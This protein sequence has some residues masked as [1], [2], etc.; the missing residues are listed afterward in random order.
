MKL[1]FPLLLLHAILLLQSSFA[2]VE[3]ELDSNAP[4]QVYTEDTIVRAKGDSLSYTNMELNGSS[5][6]PYGIMFSAQENLSFQGEYSLEIKN[7]TSNNKGY[8]IYSGRGLNFC[9]MK[10]LIFTNNVLSSSVG[11]IYVVGDMQFNQTGNI[12]LSHNKTSTAP[13]LSA[14][15]NSL[16][17]FNSTG[18]ISMSFNTGYS[19]LVSKQG[20]ISFTHIK[21]L[22]FE[23]NVCTQGDS[24]IHIR[25]LS[26]A[27]ATTLRIEYAGEVKFLNNNNTSSNKG[28]AG[29]ICASNQSAEPFIST[30]PIIFLSADNGNIL[31]QGNTHGI[32][33]WTVANAIV[34]RNYYPFNKEESLGTLSL[35]ARAQREIT[36]YDPII[37]YMKY[38][39]N[40]NNLATV[41]FN[42]SE[43]GIS[44]D[45]TIRFDGS[46]VP[47][48]IV[49]YA[50]E[51]DDTYKQRLADSRHSDIQGNSTLW[52]GFLILTNDVVYGSKLDETQP[53]TSFYCQKGILEISNRSQL[54]ATNF[55]VSGLSAVF[56]MDDS[57]LIV[58]KTFTA[59]AG[60]SFD[61]GYW[62]ENPN[63]NVM[64]KADNASF[65]G[66]IGLHDDTDTYSNNQW[67]NTLSFNLL[68][69][70][71]IVDLNNQLSGIQSQTSG[72]ALVSGPYQYSGTWS[73]EWVG[74]QLVATWTPLAG[75]TDVDP[76][77]EGNIV[78]N[79][80]WSSASNVKSLSHAALANTN[81]LRIQSNLQNNFWM[82]GIGDFAYDDSSADLDG[83][84]YDG[85]GYAAGADVK[86]APKSLIGVAFGQ[87]IGNNKSELYNAK[88]KQESMMGSIYAAHLKTLNKNNSL[89]WT[90]AGSYGDTEN[91]MS[92]H[93]S[94]GKNSTGSWNNN[95][96]FVETQLE[97]RIAP[98]GKNWT[99]KPFIGL[100]YTDVNLE[101]F[102]EKGDKVRFFDEG[103]Y[104]SLALPIGFGVEHQSRFGTKTWL[105]SL[106]LAYVPDVYREAPHTQA[107]RVSNGFSWKDQGSKAS[108]HTLRASINS[109]LQLNTA[110]TAYA[111]YTFEARG[112]ASYHNVNAGTSYS[113]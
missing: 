3:V 15:I 91:S 23:N 22:T 96:Y 106:S 50:N 78:S 70:S 90:F 31:F 69:S 97:W 49:K 41:I 76:E 53:N 27:Q 55:N 52:G 99:Y 40:S 105:N 24:T 74:T 75:I 30:A 66:M 101:S 39:E 58:T 19:V 17:T 37:T 64:I 68:D 29:V 71:N 43:N 33:H 85:G 18:D 10:D 45:G 112:G 102:T 59:N 51:S 46:K 104:K 98:E 35:R 48:Y 12:T 113:F 4:R 95:A 67:A 57:S 110:W 103:K 7:C 44:Y 8:F 107:T 60:I 32:L 5:I 80:M 28:E 20:D 56:R 6:Y 100:E 47:E 77:L 2:A 89:L 86:I 13:L 62:L 79:S 108:I 81:I 1:T 14:G 34:F 111:G 82:K 87:L 25:S 65:S 109:T 54:H 84:S 26:K 83:Y 21:S 72:S 61:V 9:N 11:L 42:Q 36:F 16:I 92:T 94:D 93:Y 38:E 63:A 73:Y 88:I